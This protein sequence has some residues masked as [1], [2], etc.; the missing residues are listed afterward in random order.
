MTFSSRDVNIIDSGTK[1]KQAK[2]FFKEREIVIKDAMSFLSGG[3]KSLPKMFKEAT[4]SLSLEKESFPHA[5][6][7]ELNFQSHWPLDH[8]NSFEDKYT[9][10]TNASKIDAIHDSKFDCEFIIVI[11]M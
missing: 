7:N 10:L 11:G 5:L 3:L 6:I 9:L 1:A 2:G 4:G 8:L